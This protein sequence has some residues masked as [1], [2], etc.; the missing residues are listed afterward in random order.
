MSNNSNDNDTLHDIL[1][2]T[3]D[4]IAK[5]DEQIE[6]GM[7]SR[8]EFS[9]LCLESSELKLSLEDLTENMTSDDIA[10][11]DKLQDYLDELN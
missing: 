1:E 2:S 5:I 6:Q 4:R 9:E 3:L 7:N 11:Y 8:M 10:Q